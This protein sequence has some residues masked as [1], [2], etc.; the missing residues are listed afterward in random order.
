MPSL[1]LSS[2]SPSSALQRW[3]CPYFFFFFFLVRRRG[4]VEL[5]L[6]SPAPLA[7]RV[8][9]TRG[10][11]RTTYPALSLRSLKRG[12]REGWGGSFGIPVP[13]TPRRQRLA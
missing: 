6:P 1:S 3:V 4:E 7:V 2:P 9:I 10:Q 12:E 5:G 11:L 13:V 8:R